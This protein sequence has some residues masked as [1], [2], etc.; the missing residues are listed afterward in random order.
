[1]MMMLIANIPGYDIDAMSIFAVVFV[2][3]AGVEIQCDRG[4]VGLVA[5]VVIHNPIECA[6]RVLATLGFSDSIDIGIAVELQ[7]PYF[8]FRVPAEESV[9]ES[10]ETVM[11]VDQ[12]PGPAVERIELGSVAETWR[13][14]SA[15]DTAHYY[16]ISRVYYPSSGS[17]EEPRAHKTSKFLHRSNR[18]R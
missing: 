13:K 12:V 10:V 14:K 11:T 9:Q 3:Q 16:I 7:S 8:R 4:L 1:M 15:S 17:K 6:E 5:R 18:S 2:P